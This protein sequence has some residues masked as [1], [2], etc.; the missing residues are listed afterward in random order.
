MSSLTSYASSV[1]NIIHKALPVDMTDTE[2]NT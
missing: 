2:K 1:K